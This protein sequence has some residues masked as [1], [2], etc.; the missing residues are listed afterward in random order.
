MVFLWHY[1][2]RGNFGGPEYLDYFLGTE[3]AWIEIGGE[4]GY[5][6][7]AKQQ[8]GGASHADAG[9]GKQE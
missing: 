2:D 6:A 4:D 9:A 8:D 7:R 3:E 1:W 5:L